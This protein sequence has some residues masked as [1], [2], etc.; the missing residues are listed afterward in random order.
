MNVLS[1]CEGVRVK[2]CARGCVHLCVWFCVNT[3]CVCVFLYM[4]CEVGAEG[5]CPHFLWEG[6]LGGKGETLLF[7]RSAPDYLSLPGVR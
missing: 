3:R 4:V 2:F 7:L 6:V 5:S 1:W